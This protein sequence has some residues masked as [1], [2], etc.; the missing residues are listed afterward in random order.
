VTWNST[1]SFGYKQYFDLD[2]I[3]GKSLGFDDVSFFSVIMGVDEFVY[4]V[5]NMASKRWPFHGT[6]QHWQR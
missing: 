3:V 1:K 2:D 4:R 6:N 5:A